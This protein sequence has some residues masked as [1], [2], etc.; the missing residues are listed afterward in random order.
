MSSHRKAKKQK[1]I[2]YIKKNRSIGVNDKRYKTRNK[3]EKGDK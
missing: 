1:K 2:L 3:R